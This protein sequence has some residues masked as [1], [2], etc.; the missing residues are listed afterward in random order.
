MS[1]YIL[2][3]TFRAV[4]TVWFTVTVVFVATRATG[5]PTEWLLPDDATTAER[6]QLRSYLGIDQPLLVQYGGY[7][8]GILRGDMG[9]SYSYARPVTEVFTERLLPTMRLGV[10]ALSLSVLV[11][12]PLGMLAAVRRNTLVDRFT[13]SVSIAGYTIPNFALGI[14][15]IF[16]FSLL[17]RV[18]P[19]GGYGGLRYLLMPVFALSVGPM[20]SIARLTRSSMLD[21]LRQDYMVAAR[22]RGVPEWAVIAKHGLRNGFIPVVTIIGLQVGELIGGSVVVETVFSWPGIGQLIVSSAQVRDYPMLQFGV[23]IVT[24]TV[25]LANLAV[26]LMYAMLD[27]RIRTV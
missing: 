26:D 16:L 13:M 27:P 8:T 14:L 19:S 12:V 6:E 2:R 11:G 24:S 20:A 18:L 25:V 15:L 17:L 3:S 23:L 9:R 5:D 10:A 1:R 7:L 4:L 22:A 21:V